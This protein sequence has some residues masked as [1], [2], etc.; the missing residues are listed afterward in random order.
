MDLTLTNKKALVLAS[1]TGLGFAIAKNLKQE[2]A[3]VAICSSDSGKLGRAASEIAA[4]YSAI[5]DL[6]EPHS[7]EK[8]VKDAAAA[9]GGLDIVVTN[10]G[11]PAKG[12]FL[13]ITQ[14]S[15]REGFQSMWM[16]VVESLHVALPIMQKQKYGRVVMV[17]STAAKEPMPKLYL[18]NGFRSGLM[19]LMKS[20]SNE[21][22]EYGIT[23]N[24]V[25]PGFTDTERLKELGAVVDQVIKKVPVRRLGKPEELA[26]LVSYLCSEKAG[27]ITGQAI[28]I[29]GGLIQG[30]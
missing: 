2:G 10:C 19:G 9:I 15:W 25:L 29:D 28:G 12:Y 24:A 11:G 6:T 13:D 3:K 18:S 27:F 4:D 16:S 20:I 8:F 21:F 26:S 22:G 7:A 17:T 14:D 30:I 5:C 1:S 23:A